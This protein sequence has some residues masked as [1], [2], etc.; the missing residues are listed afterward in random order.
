MAGD[1]VAFPPP[2]PPAQEGP[3]EVVLELE[4]LLE[5][6]R[7]GNI[8]AFI[9]VLQDEVGTDASICTDE[10]NLCMLL[11]RLRAEE[12]TLAEYLSHS[13]GSVRA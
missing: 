1:I 10:G 3:S 7:E 5:Q 12:F 2:V 4:R 11:G 8:K 13:I 6:A 9:I